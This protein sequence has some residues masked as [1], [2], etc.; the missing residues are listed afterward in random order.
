M[1]VHFF[2]ED[3][4]RRRLT[5]W[6]VAFPKTRIAKGDTWRQEYPSRLGKSTLSVH[7]YT[8]A[9][10]ARLGGQTVLRIDAKTTVTL[11][12]KENR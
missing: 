2:T 3:G 11:R 8:F 6:L 9:G 7:S 12:P 5:N 10:T 4:V 1:E